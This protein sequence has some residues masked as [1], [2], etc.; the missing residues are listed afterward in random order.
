[1]GV[2]DHLKTLV[3]HETA[4]PCKCPYST[5]Q[6]RFVRLLRQQQNL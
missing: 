6:P 2:D 3:E 1:M 4:A 5:P